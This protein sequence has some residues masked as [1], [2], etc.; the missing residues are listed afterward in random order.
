MG[1]KKV[2][3]L[4]GPITGVKNYWEAFE[5]AEDVLGGAGYI[6]LSPARL[7]WNLDNGKAMK[8]CLAMIEQADAVYFL[9]GWHNSM[10]AQFEMAY[11]KYTGKAYAC[12]LDELEEV[13]SQ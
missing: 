12:N 5:K 2:V 8:I 4:A 1:Q 10:G 7:P 3:Y 11:C 9:N 13:F 6:V